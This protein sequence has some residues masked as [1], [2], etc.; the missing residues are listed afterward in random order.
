MASKGACCGSPS[1]P[2]VGTLEYWHT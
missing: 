2:S 1:Q